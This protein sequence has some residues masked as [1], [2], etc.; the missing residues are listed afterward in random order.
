MCKMTPRQ[1]MMVAMNMGRPDRCPCAPDISNMIPAKRM[2]KP[3]WDIYYHEDPPLWQAYLD[4]SAHFGMDGWFTY[5]QLDYRYPDPVE[6]TVEVLEKTD[7]RLVAR[8]TFHT[9]KGPLSSVAIY[10]AANPPTT[11]E[12]VI[13]D[14]D[15]DFEKA[16]YLLQTPSGCDDSVFRRQKAA[17]GESGVMCA[18]AISPGL[19]TLF[20]LFE[21][22]LEALTYA[23]T[24]YPE[25][26]DELVARSQAACVEQCRLAIAAGADSILTGGSGSITM[27]SPTLWRQHSLP[28]I[29]EITRMC[30][31]SG[32]I[33]GI[34][35]CGL[36]MV[37]VETCAN[38]TELDYINPLEI[39]PMGDSSLAQARRAAHGRLCLMGNLHTSEVML[40]GSPDMVRRESL[41]AL[42]DAGADG[43]FVLSTGDQCGRDTP[44]ENIFAM[45]AA[46]EE[47]GQ[48]PLDIERI[49]A[50]IRRLDQKLS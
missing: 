31:A 42:L 8:T 39:P 5:G 32:V 9:P 28:A 17:L 33:S 44:E 15:A 6:K 41:K 7:E 40:F 27:S 20:D 43:A 45:V 4:A 36:E 37:I 16:L 22:G 47:L 50:E 12:K 11:C 30:R 35:S 1:R 10:P 25:L 38:E 26:F 14:L 46:M 13:K 2:G 18:H 34:H 49:E 3:F 21:G 23:M 48:Y 29:K 19:H 24:D